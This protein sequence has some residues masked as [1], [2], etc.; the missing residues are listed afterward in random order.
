MPMQRLLDLLASEGV[1][2]EVLRHRSDVRAQETA[3]DTHTPGREFAKTVVLDVGRHGHAFSVVPAS[4]RLDLEKVRDGIGTRDV[5]LATED[6][7]SALCPECEVGAEP[8][9]GVLFDVPV[10]VD[11]LLDEDTI[12]FNAGSHEEAIRMRYE[13]F[14]RL[15][16]P[17]VMD[18]VEVR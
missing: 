16:H 17:V 12:T 15:V 13:D 3:A 5:H 18:L 14:V 8:P 10:Y 4:F 2:F 11:G 1:S 7:M 6:E 9:F